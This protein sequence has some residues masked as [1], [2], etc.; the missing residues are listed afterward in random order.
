MHHFLSVLTSSKFDVFSLIKTENRHTT[1]YRRRKHSHKVRYFFRLRGRTMSV[2]KRRRKIVCFNF[3][4][5]VEL[6]YATVLPW[7]PKLPSNKWK[8]GRGDISRA[9]SLIAGTSNDWRRSSQTSNSQIVMSV[10]DE[11]YNCREF[12]ES[13][14]VKRFTCAFI[15]DLMCC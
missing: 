2:L 6:V 5:R 14:C 1:Y 9:S 12:D 3:A 4:N 15:S 11:A 7:Q 10:D 13:I 8:R